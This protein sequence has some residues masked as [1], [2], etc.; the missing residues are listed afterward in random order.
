MNPNWISLPHP[1]KIGGF[2]AGPIRDRSLRWAGGR[3][4]SCLFPSSCPLPTWV[5]NSHVLER[6]NRAVQDLPMAKKNNQ[7][8]SKFTTQ[9][10]GSFTLIFGEI[11]SL[12]NSDF[13]QDFV[14]FGWISFRPLLVWQR[15]SLLFSELQK[16]ACIE[17]GGTEVHL[18]QR[19][20]RHKF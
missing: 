6:S 19:L 10:G 4:K 7:N 1:K 8:C 20:L 13:V 15:F 14:T 9:T 16:R 12:P 11:L 5:T 17:K 2:E 3:K 18:P